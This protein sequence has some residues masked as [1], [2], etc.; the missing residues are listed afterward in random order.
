[1][2][3]DARAV[4]VRPD[5]RLVVGGGGSDAT[6]YG[7]SLLGLLADGTPDTAFGPGGRLVTPMGGGGMYH[8]L[9]RR[10]DGRIVAAAQ[11]STLDRLVV[12]RYAALGGADAPQ[13]PAGTG[14]A[15]A[16]VPPPGVAA[17]PRGPA[18]RR[19]SSRLL[20]VRSPV[21]S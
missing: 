9:H 15:E 18:G 6:G 14:E 4:V 20:Q 1:M 11:I 19:R 17:A 2:L 10:P 21:A 3:G 16:T 7:P 5:G 13:P 8:A 12:A